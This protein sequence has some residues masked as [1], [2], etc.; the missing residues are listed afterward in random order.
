MLTLFLWNQLVSRSNFAKLCS[1]NKSWFVSQNYPIGKILTYDKSFFSACSLSM[2]SYPQDYL[3]YMLLTSSRMDLDFVNAE[4]GKLCSQNSVGLRQCETSTKW[5][6]LIYWVQITNR[7][8]VWRRQGKW[9]NFSPMYAHNPTSSL[10]FSS[11]NYRTNG[12]TRSISGQRC[13]ILV[14]GRFEISDSVVEP[15]LPPSQFSVHVTKVS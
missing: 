8:N 11:A 12:G 10:F 3:K 9:L 1:F 15:A 5:F 6:I 14:Q 4:C 2:T 7:F 13:R